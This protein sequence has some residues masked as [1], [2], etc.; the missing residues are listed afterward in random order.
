MPELETWCVRSM[1]RA[2]LRQLLWLG[3]WCAQL[4]GPEAPET[5][6]LR[7]AYL[8]AAS[9]A[10]GRGVDVGDVKRWGE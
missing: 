9:G 3:S 10:K 2:V 4:L 8:A 1:F 6:A 7:G 5:K